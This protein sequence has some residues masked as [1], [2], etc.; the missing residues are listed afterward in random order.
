M[1][2]P[3]RRAHRIVIPAMVAILLCALAFTLAEPPASPLVKQLP[4]EIRQLG[5]SR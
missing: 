5:E 4:V 1:I 2:Q 3:L